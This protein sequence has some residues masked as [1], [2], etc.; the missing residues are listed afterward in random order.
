MFKGPDLPDQMMGLANPVSI[1]PFD[2]PGSYTGCTF[3]ASDQNSNGKLTCKDSHEVTCKYVKKTDGT[4]LLGC[5]GG[6]GLIETYWECN[7]P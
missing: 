6:G 7:R 3:D 2:L 4:T 1:G 5:L